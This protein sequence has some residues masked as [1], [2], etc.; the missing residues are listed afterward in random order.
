[1]TACEGCLTD[2]GGLGAP[3]PSHC[4]SCPP[5]KC[6]TCGGANHWASGHYCQCWL[7]MT[8]IAPA[9]LKGLF[10]AEGPDDNGLSV[11]VQR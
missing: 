6:S 7:D 10:A 9:D 11:E 4:P 2:V 1:M 3:E 5:E 8:G